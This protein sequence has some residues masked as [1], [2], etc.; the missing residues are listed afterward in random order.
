MYNPSKK[1]S[2][3]EEEKFPSRRTWKSERDNRFSRPA[4]RESAHKL[5]RPSGSSA[6][7]AEEQTPKPAYRPREDGPPRKTKEFRGRIN[8]DDEELVRRSDSAAE[9]LSLKEELK[10]KRKELEWKVEELSEKRK[11]VQDQQVLINT[12]KNKK[13]KQGTINI[14][15]ALNKKNTAL[16]EDKKKLL[17]DNKA[18]KAKVKDLE[19]A[20][21]AF[22]NGKFK[23]LEVTKERYRK[24]RNKALLDLESSSKDNERLRKDKKEA[25]D[26]LETSKAEQIKQVDRLKE[27]Q[28][29]AKEVLR[30]TIA[31]LEER[32]RSL[33]LEEPEGETDPSKS[34][35]SNET[36][37]D[38]DVE[39]EEDDAPGKEPTDASPELRPLNKSFDDAPSPVFVA[40]EQRQGVRKRGSRRKLL[41]SQDGEAG[42]SLAQVLEADSSFDVIPT[43]TKRRGK[44]IVTNS[45]LA[46]PKS[47]PPTSKA[48][49]YSNRNFAVTILNEQ[50]SFIAVAEKYR[51]RHDEKKYG[52]RPCGLYPTCSSMLKG[53][54]D[55][56]KVFVISPEHHQSYDKETWACHFH[57]E[58]SMEGQEVQ[59]VKTQSTTAEAVETPAKDDAE[60]GAETPPAPVKTKPKGPKGGIEK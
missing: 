38:S 33:T 32:V 36:S 15:E 60:E 31:N 7:A 46:K 22:A 54:E 26:D 56:S 1:R 34:P 50:I 10:D 48:M 29:D 42:S 51:A 12:L 57:A 35:V 41:P 13:E 27:N 17:E 44:K 8:F 19:T 14:N 6:R 18:L 49:R 45:T 47:S 43:S 28:K 30:R 5:S 58:A 2:R 16:K 53:G 24:E 25:L 11:E 59:T 9:I 20:A 55:I 23:D 39:A 21:A 4:S 37:D 40:K 3:S 52:T